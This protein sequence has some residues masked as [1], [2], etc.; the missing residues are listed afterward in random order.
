MRNSHLSENIHSTSVILN[1]MKTALVIIDVQSYFL[2]KSPQ[3]LPAKIA[4]HIR[5]SDYDV[6]VFTIFQN[7]T[8]S[9]WVRTLHWTKSNSQED[10][11]LPPEF[12]EFI[13][14][15]VFIKHSYSAFKGEGFEE[16]LK[17]HK[18]QKLE[19]CGIDLEA[20]VLATAYEAF[21]KD[22]EVKV[23][24]ELSHSRADLDEAAKSIILR[25]I[26]TKK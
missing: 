17:T 3:D 2:Q 20:C 24:F 14:D 25:D 21:D 4:N 19:I 18:I 23:L 11:E 5:H 26:Q 6:V 1:K 13:Q 7:E 12:K 8:N 9:N 10:L 22:Y 16:H 15:N